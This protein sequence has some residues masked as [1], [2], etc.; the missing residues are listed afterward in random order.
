[1]FQS[2]FW[3]RSDDEDESEQR[4]N[5]LTNQQQKLFVSQTQLQ[6]ENETQPQTSKLPDFH[7]IEETLSNENGISTV[8]AALASNIV[9]L[10]SKME[11]RSKERI[12][13]DEQSMKQNKEQQ[14]KEIL[15][16]QQ[17]LKEELKH[18]I[19]ETDKVVAK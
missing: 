10:T 9:E 3:N 13:Q 8:R 5:D 7:S 11:Q 4:T 18:V 2:H 15:A 17:H 19:E 6:C 14:T 12:Q 16:H 1:M